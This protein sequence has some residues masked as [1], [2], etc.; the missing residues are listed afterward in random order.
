MCRAVNYFEHFLVFISVVS[1]CVSISAFA[2]LVG[3][4]IGITSSAVGMKI[5][6]I[7]AGIKRYKSIINK[8]RKKYDEIE[9]SA[10][11]KS[12]AIEVLIYKA[13]HDSCINHEEFF[14]VSNVLREYNEIIGEI[15]NSENDVENTI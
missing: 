5:C 15:K 7:T 13:L 12:S 9:L 3:V 14:S 4:P 1:G 6:A 11:T 8:K 2:S 10:K